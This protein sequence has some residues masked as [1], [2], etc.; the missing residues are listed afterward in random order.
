M[1]YFV[2][3]MLVVGLITGLVARALVPGRDPMGCLGTIMLGLAGSFVGGFLS[4]LIQ[5]RTLTPHRFHASGI[6][7]SIVGAVLLLLLLRLFRHRA[8]THHY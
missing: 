1:L 3:V 2:L 5:Y 4:S 6:I 7:W 8:P